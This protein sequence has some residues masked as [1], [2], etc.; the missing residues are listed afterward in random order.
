MKTLLNYQS[1]EWIYNCLF[2][3]MEM[4]VGIGIPVKEQLF[5]HNPYY[6]HH[7]LVI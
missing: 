1:L 3:G 5:Q 7:L 2:S 6:I 4:V